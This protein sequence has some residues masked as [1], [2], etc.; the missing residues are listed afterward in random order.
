M[1]AKASSSN[2]HFKGANFD[3]PLFG[4]L[5]D[6]DALEKWLNMLEAYY[7]FQKCSDNKKI[8][9]VLLKSLPHVRAWWEGY[10]ER[11]TMDESMPFEREST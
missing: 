11:Y 7:F 3:I 2:N 9:F 5:I 1:M 6:A 8:T 10:W 4:G